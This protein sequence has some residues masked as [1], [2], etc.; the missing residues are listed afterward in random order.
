[1]GMLS[2][3]G[4]YLRNQFKKRLGY[5]SYKIGG[6]HANKASGMVPIKIVNFLRKNVKNEFR[7]KLILARM[8]RESPRKFGEYGH[9]AFVYDKNKVPLVDVPEL[10]DCEVL[11]I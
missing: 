9:N 11:I 2:V 4:P 8:V 6:K 10:K 1:M 3:V 7:A 5:Y